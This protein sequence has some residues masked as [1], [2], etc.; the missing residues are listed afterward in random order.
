M[1][2]KWGFKPAVARGPSHPRHERL[3][4]LARSLDALARKDETIIR[5]TREISA[6]RRQA[7][8]ELHTVCADFVRD[9]NA[10]LE[11]IEIDFQP[12]EYPA[13]NFH[14]DGINLFQLNARGRILQIR[15]EATP[16]LTSTEDFRVPYI[17]AGTVRCFNQQLLEKDLIEE[18]ALFYTVE[19]SRHLWRFFDARTYHVGPFDADYLASLL[20]QLV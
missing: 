5:R 17:L 1:K 11:E 13:E 9:L 12:D 18:Q 14:D 6:L 4:K 8:L 3:K 20:E 10:L 7:A 19:K 2:A 16:E 15:F